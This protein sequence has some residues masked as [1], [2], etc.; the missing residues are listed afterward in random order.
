M[1]WSEDRPPLP[2]DWERRRSRVFVRD[3]RTCQ[4]QFTGCT[5]RATEVDHIDSNADHTIKNLRA[6]C[7]D[8]HAKRTQEQAAEA[9]RAAWAKTRVP[10]PKHPGLL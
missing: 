9:L 4:L 10:R 7:H 6:V 3:R 1:A 8:C 2:P 5:G